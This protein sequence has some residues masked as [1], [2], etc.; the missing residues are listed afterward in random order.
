MTVLRARLLDRSSQEQQEEIAG[1][2]K[3]QVG[4]GGALREDPH[5]Q[6]PAGPPDRPSYRPDRT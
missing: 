6:F 2:R 4:G 1:A 5:V 3:Q